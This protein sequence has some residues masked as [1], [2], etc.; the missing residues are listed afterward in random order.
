MDEIYQIYMERRT[1]G[2]IHER[3]YEPPM[4]EEEDIEFDDDDEKPSRYPF[5]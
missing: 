2:E 3:L 1:I 4:E 5:N